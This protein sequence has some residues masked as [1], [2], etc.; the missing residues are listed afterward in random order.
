MVLLQVLFRQGTNFARALLLGACALAPFRWDQRCELTRVTLLVNVW[1]SHKPLG[2]RPLPPGVATKLS[3]GCRYP[4]PCFNLPMDFTPVAVGEA[5]EAGAMSVQNLRAV[6]GS[7]LVLDI[8]VPMPDALVTLGRRG[9][10]AFRL[11]FGHAHPARITSGSD[12]SIDSHQ[13]AHKGKGEPT[14][15]IIHR[16][17]GPKHSD[18][19]GGRSSAAP[20]TV[21]WDVRDGRGGG[22]SDSPVG[23]GSAVGNTKRKRDGVRG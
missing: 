3:Q 13:K 5:A 23:K 12:T 22:S 9:L 7:N 17:G 16:M 15:T 20:E 4:V 1:V 10:S 21:R 2:V 19:S 14:A 6:L 11:E 8:C 18:R